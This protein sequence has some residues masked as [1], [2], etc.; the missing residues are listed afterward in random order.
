MPFQLDILQLRAVL[1]QVFEQ[2]ALCAVEFSIHGNEVEIVRGQGRNAVRHKTFN[3][4]PDAK[5]GKS[6]AAFDTD[7]G[8]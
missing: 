4:F 6:R 5:G 8:S 2:L 7:H 3:E 1:Q